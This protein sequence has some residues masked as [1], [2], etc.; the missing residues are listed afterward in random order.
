MGHLAAF[1]KELRDRA[2]HKWDTIIV[3]D[4]EPGV[5]KSALG[6]QICR[7]VDPDFPPENTAYSSED[8]YR[9]YR[10]LGPG[11]CM[12]YDES[13]L[14]MLGQGG[15]RSEELR[16]LVQALSIVRLKRIT[17]VCCIP[18]IRLLDAFVKYGRARYWI[19]VYTRGRG[20]IH[21]SWQGAKYRTSVSRLPYDSYTDLSPIGF[22]NL[23]RSRFWKDYEVQKLQRVNE[24]LEIHAMDP[25]GRLSKCVKCG[26]VA[27]KYQIATHSCPAGDRAAGPT[28]SP[29]LKVDVPERSITRPACVCAGCGNEWVPRSPS[30]GRCPKCG[31]YER[32]A[33]TWRKERQEMVG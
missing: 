27:S 23:D 33:V 19:H 7:G 14:G 26:K 24:W 25:D 13:V 4:G 31:S 18:D 22:R 29:V 8:A 15:G 1:C 30:G 11:E 28:K 2:R 12:L 17:T 32:R 3:V 6:I 16:S 9:L 10:T 5:G 21:R 20:K